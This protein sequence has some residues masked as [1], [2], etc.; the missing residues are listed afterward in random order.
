ML[1]LMKFISTNEIKKN[2]WH[3]K[4]MNCMF[5]LLKKYRIRIGS[6][7]FTLKNSEKI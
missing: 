7:N 3:K 2:I 1:N 6:S 4:I 5:L